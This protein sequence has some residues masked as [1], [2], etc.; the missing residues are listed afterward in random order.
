MRLNL[1]HMDRTCIGQQFVDTDE[2]VLFE[3][4]DVVEGTDD[5]ILFHED[6]PTLIDKRRRYSYEHTLCKEILNVEW[7]HWIV[8]AKKYIRTSHYY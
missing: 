5:R 7:V 2:N 8:H 1:L 3:I 6:V 4:A